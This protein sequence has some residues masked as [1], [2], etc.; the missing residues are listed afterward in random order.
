MSQLDNSI[1][2]GVGNVSYD[3]KLGKYYQNF[4]PAIIHITSSGYYTLDENEIPKYQG[5]HYPVIVIQYALMCHD[6]L[7]DNFDA[8]KNR[9]IVIK[10][11]DWLNSNKEEFKDSYV[12]KNPRNKHYN[13][14]SGW[15]SGMCQGQALSLYLRVYQLIGNKECLEIANK[16][17]NSFKHDYE[18][19]GFKRIDENDNIWFE[20]YPTKNPSFVLNGFCYSIFGVLDFYRVTKKNELAQLWSSCISTIEN[21]LSKYDVWYWSL[22]DQQKKELVSFYYQKNVHIPLLLILYELTK[23]NIFKEYADKW[24]RNLDSP[25]CRVITKIMYRIKPRFNSLLE[26]KC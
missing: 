3:Q 9:R 5:V 13:L 25:F 18:D 8:D 14:E 2:L 1:Y 24:K 22:Y 4:S 6:L 15:V 7:I 11:I 20:E 26:R 16:I 12:W 17:Y 19:G 23:K 10:C 21:N